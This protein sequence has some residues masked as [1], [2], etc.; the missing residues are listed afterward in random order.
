MRQLL[1][2]MTLWEVKGARNGETVHD[3]GAWERT[4]KVCFTGNCR[5]SRF[6]SF[7]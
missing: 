4:G 7:S 1:L 5:K 6:L 3:Q 2:Q